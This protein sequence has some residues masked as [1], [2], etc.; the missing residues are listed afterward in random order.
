MGKCKGLNRLPF[1]LGITVTGEKMNK[2][3]T[4]YINKPKYEL[5]DDGSFVIENYNKAKTFSSFFPGI[6][7]L[8]GIPMWAFYVNRGQGIAAFGIKNKNQSI[9]EFY[10]ANNAYAFTPA[11]GFRTFLKITRKSGQSFYEPFK[12]QKDPA[13]TQR[14][15]IRPHEMAIE[16]ENSELGIKT[17]VTYFTLPNEPLAALAR[18]TEISNISKEKLRVEVVDGMAKIVPYWVD[19]WVQKFMSNTAQAWVT[20]ESALDN[21]MF[22]RL[23]VEI[24]DVPE[25]HELTKGN[26]FAGSYGA[27]EKL[28]KSAVITDPRIIFGEDN[29]LSYPFGFFQEG[30][31]KIPKNQFGANKYPSAFGYADITLMPKAKQAMY[32]LAGHIDSLA[33][34]KEFGKK[35]CEKSY[36][37]K[38][39][40]ENKKLIDSLTD[41]IS[42]RSNSKIFDLYAKQTYL[43]NMMRGGKPI[44]FTDGGK[45]AV[46]YVYSRKHGDLERDYNNFELSPHYYS[47][48]NGNYR[49]MNQNKR[50]DIFFN[51]R[52]GDFNVRYFYNLIQ[53]DGFN[54]LVVKGQLFFFDA[55]Q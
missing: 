13:I 53:L 20:T 50:N 31:L 34:L 38:K 14:M 43:D 24:N 29:S 2:Q 11:L 7:G 30:D 4:N 41:D 18:I 28:S 23:K 3:R 32:S 22:Y 44:V 1:T 12:A 33:L 45:Q 47:Q 40:S 9:M 51:P 52:I 49:D 35:A 6:A 17:R 36:F 42:T 54:P 25:V 16:D 46:F 15:I 27:C 48:G 55:S 8:S 26:F 21:A 5:K 39:R 37:E 10:P 19:Q